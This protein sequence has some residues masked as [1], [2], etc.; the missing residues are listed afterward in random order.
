[1]LSNIDSPLRI[2]SETMARTIT[3]TL[4]GAA[5]CAGVIGIEAHAD[6]IGERTH[7][8]P[9]WELGIGVGGVYLPD[10]RG[11]D[12]Q[13]GYLVPWPFAAYRGERITLDREGFQ[14]RLFGSPHVK[15]VASLGVSTPVKSDKN[16]ARADMP[17]LDFAFEAG[18]MLE[19]DLW[20]SPSHERIAF[21]LPLRGVIV[22]DFSSDFTG[23]GWLLAPRLTW[24]AP[25]FFRHYDVEATVGPLFGS[26]EYHDY[27]YRVDPQY[28][29][30]QRPAYDAR[31]G[32]SGARFTLGGSRRF[33]K[34]WS[35]VY[36]R[37]DNLAGAVFGDS[38]LVRADN[39]LTIGGGIAYI[40]ATAKPG[41]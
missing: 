9:R 7:E 30:A 24:Y 31:A 33:G 35:G 17:D 40:F 2:F 5:L 20:R 26:N 6:D 13:G 37:Y 21:Q 16:V 36:L 23:A 32:Y 18:P 27:Y 15:I 8:L 12:E 3:R 11:S 28:A 29:T 1:M 41:E 34:I 38:P 22:T 4:I 19:V 39:A 14:G 10:Y 25:Y